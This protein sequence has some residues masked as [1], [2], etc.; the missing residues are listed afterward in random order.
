MKLLLDENLSRRLV[1][2]L[3]VA[4][5]GTTHIAFVGLDGASDLT[6]CDFAALHDFVMVTKD[7]DFDRLV[8]LRNFNPK[9]IR[10][11]LG[12]TSNAATLQALL[13]AAPEITAAL[14]GPNRGVVELGS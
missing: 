11:T 2:A 1:A 4:Y 7:E 12:N 10:L 8:A 13:S 14:T 5:P 3:Q 9:L 6:I